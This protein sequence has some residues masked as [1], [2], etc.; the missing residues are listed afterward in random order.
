M[1]RLLTVGVF[2]FFTFVGKSQD[3]ISNPLINS[4]Q[5]LSEG[6]SF[7]DKEQY[8]SAM[9]DIIRLIEMTPI[10]FQHFMRNPFH[11]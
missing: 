7:H 8:D 5:L 6:I 3:S 1:K 2:A 10:I 9:P 11:Y 4:G